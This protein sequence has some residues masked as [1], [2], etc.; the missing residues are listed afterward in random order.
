MSFRMFSFSFSPSIS[1]DNCWLVGF[2]TNLFEPL[3]PRDFALD[4]S[5]LHYQNQIRMKRSPIWW[6][7]MIVVFPLRSC[8]IFS[9][10]WCLFS[11]YCRQGIIQDQDPEDFHDQPSTHGNCCFCPPERETPPPPSTVSI[12]SGMANTSRLHKLRA[13]ITLSLPWS[14]W[15]WKGHPKWMRI[16]AKWGFILRDIA[17]S[18]FKIL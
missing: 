4:L 18:S 9:M 13:F 12:W 6:A 1:S 14:G 10:I 8:F 7:V 11:I 17:G 2:S 16:M 5:I 15:S 3:I